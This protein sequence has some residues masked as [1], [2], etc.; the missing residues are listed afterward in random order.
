M[1]IVFGLVILIAGIEYL[2]GWPDA[3]SLEPRRG[4]SLP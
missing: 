3:L 2:F 1:L 4:L